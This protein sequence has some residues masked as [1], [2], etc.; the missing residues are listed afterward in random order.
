MPACRLTATFL[1]LLCASVPAL[2]A[3]PP[4]PARPNVLFISFDDLN[5]WITPLGGHPQPVTPNFDRL[6][7]SS[8]LF[9][10]AYCAAPSCNPSQ[11]YFPQITSQTSNKEAACNPCRSLLSSSPSC[12]KPVISPPGT[13]W[14]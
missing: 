9:K 8:V 14:I 7:K 1:I 13:K 12:R 11:N 3:A 2:H 5:D 6:A 4:A 10:N